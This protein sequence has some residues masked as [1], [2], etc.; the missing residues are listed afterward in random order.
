MRRST[1]LAISVLSLA[2]LAVSASA[3]AREHR[4]DSPFATVRLVSKGD[5][6]AF[7][8]T[9]VSCFVYGPAGAIPGASGIACTQAKLE[10]GGVIDF[11]NPHDVGL[12]TV[13]C[14]G[15][16]SK[17]EFDGL[18][19]FLD[20]STSS[21]EIY[22]KRLFHASL[23][24]L[25]RLRAEHAGGTLACHGSSGGRLD[26]RPHVVCLIVNAHTVKLIP[27][28]IV[29]YYY[30]ASRTDIG[31]DKQRRNRVVVHGE[32]GIL[33]DQAEADT[34]DIP[35]NGPARLKYRYAP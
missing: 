15:G 14:P 7:D 29:G 31:F 22:E 18:G 1:A 28:G 8:G 5:F 13:C 25:V 17:I 12:I 33:V 2:A 21:Y 9:S 3:L 23:H 26:R 20:F 10:S 24:S 30:S 34:I 11:L 27:S 32:T 35:R 4:P 16:T 6:V 19:G